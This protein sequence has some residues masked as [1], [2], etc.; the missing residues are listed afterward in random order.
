MEPGRFNNLPYPQQQPN[1]QRPNVS[2]ANPAAA[3]NGRS[4]TNQNFDD[5]PETGLAALEFLRRTQSQGG[6]I[7]E[8]VTR[9]RRELN[10]RDKTVASIQ[11][12]RQ[13]SGSNAASGSSGN[14]HLDK[15]G[16]AASSSSDTSLNNNMSKT[17][18]YKKVRKTFFEFRRIFYE[19]LIFFRL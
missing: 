4:N 1:L 2:A 19:M 11:A 8:H 12:A 16:E 18:Q 5:L 7:M 17:H 15:A 13:R 9:L 3:F 10:I 6:D 14:S